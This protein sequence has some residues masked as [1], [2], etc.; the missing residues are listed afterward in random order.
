MCPFDVLDLQQPEWE[1]R[2]LW[3]PP[4]NTSQPP[5][6]IPPAPGGPRSWLPLA[7]P[8]PHTQR[9]APCLLLPGHGPP[10]HHGVQHA[11]P[12]QPPAIGPAAHGES[13]SPTP[14]N[15]ST[16]YSREGGWE[17]SRMPMFWWGPSTCVQG[18]GSDV[19]MGSAEYEGWAWTVIY[20]FTRLT[21]GALFLYLGII[22]FIV[23]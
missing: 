13:L 10:S 3:D 18:M 17:G 14:P 6:A 15:G 22:C 9:T 2:R 16:G 11:S 8:Q 23:I 12:G 7:V 20:V 1:Q 19:C 4:D 21:S 5:W